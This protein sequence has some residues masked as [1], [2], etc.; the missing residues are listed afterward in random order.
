MPPSMIVGEETE[1]RKNTAIK[2]SLRLFQLS[3]VDSFMEW[4]GDDEVTR[5]CR[6][7]TY[8]SKDDA[9]NLLK[10]VIRSHPWYRAVCVDGRPIGSIYVMPGTGKDERRGEIGYAFGVKHW[11][12]GI[13]TMA[14]KL[15]MSTVFEEMPYLERVEG[16]VFAENVASQRV[17]EKAGFVRDGLLRKYFFVKGKSRDIVVYSVVPGEPSIES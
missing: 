5:Y 13:A 17:L 12:Q 6:W 8:T 14:V 16:L 2:I 9:L 3:D 10:D 11:G 15:V 1:A 7:D 4:A